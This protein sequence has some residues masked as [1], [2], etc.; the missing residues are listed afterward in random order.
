[1]NEIN[2]K[3]LKKSYKILFLAALIFILVI[4]FV[5]FFKKDLRS[6]FN[7]TPLSPGFTT[8]LESENVLDFKKLPPP[9]KFNH[10]IFNGLNSKLK[11]K[12]TCNDSFYTI[13]IFKESDDY[14]FNP[15]LSKFNSAFPCNKE[16]QIEKEIDLKDL[17]FQPGKYYYIIADQGE[18]GT[19][20]NPR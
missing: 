14:R 12:T 15:Q 2:K 6:N 11:I 1:M 7:V 8:S 18:K 9:S 13:L 4:F 17:N 16:E 5:F 19:W 20:Y 3:I 10:F